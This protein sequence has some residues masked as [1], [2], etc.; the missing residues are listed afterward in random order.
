MTN[1][2]FN[3]GV[4]S[5]DFIFDCENCDEEVCTNCNERHLEDCEFIK[6]QKSG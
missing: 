5:P 3:C 6:K 1:V 4:N 2:C